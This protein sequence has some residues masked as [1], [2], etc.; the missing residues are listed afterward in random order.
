MS[1][2]LTIIALTGD[3]GAAVC[4]AADELRTAL[5]FAVRDGNTKNVTETIDALR[6]AGAI[7]KNGTIAKSK[8]GAILTCLLDAANASA[9]AR[10]VFM[11]EF[12]G[13]KG[14]PSAAMTDRARALVG[15]IVEVFEDSARTATTPA[16]RAPKVDTVIKGES[17]ETGESK[18]ESAETG[19]STESTDVETL[20]NT[21]VLLDAENARLKEENDRLKAENAALI[22]ELSTIKKTPAKRTRQHAPV[23]V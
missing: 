21:I 19:E 3:K 16:K 10:G 2:L 4:A 7:L 23:A 9:S 6:D 22:A 20:R 11:G 18:G 17:A 15:A 14:R 8:K 12:H 1:K 13:H 5:V